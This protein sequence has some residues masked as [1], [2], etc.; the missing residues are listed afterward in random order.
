MLLDNRPYVE[1]MDEEGS[2]SLPVVQFHATPDGFTDLQSRFCDAF[3]QL[4]GNGKKA[5]LAA[6]YAEV[7]AEGMGIRNLANPKINAEI[8]R[9]LKLQGSTLLAIALGG[10]LRII[11]TSSDPKAVVQACVAICDR[12]G[13]SVPKGPA[14]A[15][16]I[17]NTVNGDGAQAL[18]QEIWE[19]RQKRIANDAEGL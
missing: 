9:R 18:L 13:L 3:I 8:L 10:L 5:A 19:E 15:V 14:V 1:G 11:E 12:F 7:S 16:Q 6:G 2:G 4:G 17:N